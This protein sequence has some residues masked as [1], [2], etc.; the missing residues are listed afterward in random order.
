MIRNL[1]CT[2]IDRLIGSAAR[3]ARQVADAEARLVQPAR[4]PR[5][6]VATTPAPAPAGTGRR[7]RRPRIMVPPRRGRAV[8]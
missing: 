8:L 2:L 4:P 5:W 1:C 6:P 3:A 7:T